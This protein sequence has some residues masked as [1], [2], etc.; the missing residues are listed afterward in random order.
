M[1]EF[2]RVEERLGPHLERA[3][4]KGVDTRLSPIIR[5]P[6]EMAAAGPPFV[7]MALEA[8]VLTAP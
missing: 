7:G 6:E 3:K 8:R 1:D 4:R 2:S 5:S